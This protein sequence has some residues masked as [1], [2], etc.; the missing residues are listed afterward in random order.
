MKAFQTYTLPSI[1]AGIYDTLQCVFIMIAF[2]FESVCKT[3]LAL[4]EL[5]V[6]YSAYN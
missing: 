4:V 5:Y 2:L 6:Q 3:N 1:P